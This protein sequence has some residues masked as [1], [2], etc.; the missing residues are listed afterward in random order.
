[1]HMKRSPHHQLFYLH[2]PRSTTS[3]LHHLTTSF[4]T[5]VKRWPSVFK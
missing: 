4:I 1:M 2:Q 3:T 5:P